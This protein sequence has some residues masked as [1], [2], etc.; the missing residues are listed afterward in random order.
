MSTIQPNLRRMTLT[1][2]I[3]LLI[4]FAWN[5]NLALYSPPP[6]PPPLA[7]EANPAILTHPPGHPRL[8]YFD[9]SAPRAPFVT[10]PLARLCAETSF[11]P[12][13]V[14]ICDNNSG[15]PGNIRNYILTCLRYAL[16]SGATALVT[17]RIR[18]RSPSD[19]ADLFAGGYQPLD[20][21]FNR[22]HFAAGL[23]AACPRLALHDALED[24]PGVSA[25]AA[26]EGLPPER[27]TLRIAPRDFGSRAGCDARDVNRHTDRFPEAFRAWMAE[28][29]RD[30]GLAPTSWENP[31]VVRLAWGVLWDWTTWRD[32]P[33]FA[34]TFGG[35]LRVREDIL[36]VAEDLVRAMDGLARS[37][38]GEGRGV[39][40][41]E[42]RYL[43]VH[44]RTE[45]DALAQWPSYED[46]SRAY[47]REA[48]RQGFAGGVAYLASGSETEAHKFATDA[49]EGLH[50]TVR[51]KFDVLQDTQLTT[52]R[53]MSWDQQAL[54]DFVVLLGADYFVGVSPSSFSINVALKRH[55]RTEGLQ[56]RPWRV[57][58]LGDGRSW[59]VGQYE[60]YWDDWLFMFDGL[61]P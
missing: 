1:A 51:S 36:K 41:R 28:R 30:F 4:I 32:G 17:P 8:S 45:Q 22:S 11:I 50:L 16:A 35:L 14:Y 58:G 25:R 49:M 13:V 21:M 52:L 18:T 19:P 10:W 42:R 3:C 5:Y 40:G 54:V 44:L 23:A 34:A 7:V 38:S 39:K 9:L 12:G 20:Y 26:R 31:L 29:A 2:V 15:G 56:T 47:L 48:E 57:G 43:G 60:K 37:M 61:W 33:E 59:L 24:V 6:P 55:L 46:Q 27:T 53:A